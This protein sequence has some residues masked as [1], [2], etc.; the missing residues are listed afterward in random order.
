[1]CS[2]QRHGCSN[3][4]FSPPLPP[5]VPCL[6]FLPLSIS[7]LSSLCPSL[8]LSLSVCVPMLCSL[9][10]VITKEGEQIRAFT[11]QDVY[12]RRHTCCPVSPCK[13]LNTRTH[14]PK[15]RD[16]TLQSSAECAYICMAHEK[17]CKNN[18]YIYTHWKTETI[19]A[20]CEKMIQEWTSEYLHEEHTLMSI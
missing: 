2:L 6:R 16:K 17:H 13:G 19:Y 7:L 8:S 11:R 14:T 3:K 10:S 4:N 1:M 12:M 9:V 15:Q 5:S 20:F 18:I